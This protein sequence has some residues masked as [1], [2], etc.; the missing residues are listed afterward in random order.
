[1]GARLATELGEHG[2]RGVDAADPN[3]TLG[4]RHCDAPGADRQLERCPVAGQVGQDVDGGAD[5]SR[6]E[7]RA[8][9]GVVAGGSVVVPDLVRHADRL[10]PSRCPRQRVQPAGGDQLGSRTG[11]SSLAS[12]RPRA[13]EEN[14]VVQIVEAA[15]VTPALVEAFERL[16]PQLSRSNP[17]P[18]AHMLGAI[19]G[20]ERVPSADRD[21]RERRHRRHAHP[22]RLPDPDRVAGVDRRRHRRRGRQRAGDRP[23]ADRAHARPGPRLWLHNG[24]P[25]VPPVRARPRTTS[26]RRSG[27]SRARRNVYR[28]DLRA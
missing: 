26:T 17:A 16:T 20:S 10:P 23:P 6:L 9:A 11:D 8:V 3:A 2:C 24:R 5:R 12:G 15:E 4:E 28:Y 25:H 7:V 27:S 21:R 14:A 1:M 19:I 18:D 13:T 22:H